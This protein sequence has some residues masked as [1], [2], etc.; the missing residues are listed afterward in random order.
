MDLH[1]QLEPIA[2]LLGDW[3]GGGSGEF[4]TIQPFRYREELHF[5]H[6]GK[7]ILNYSQRTFHADDGR[8]LHSESGYWR[9]TASG[10]VEVLLAHTTGHVEL[11]LGSAAGPHIDLRS[12]TLQGAPS[13]KDV[14]GVERRYQLRDDLLLAEFSM[15][16]MGE[17]MTLHLRSALRR[18]DSR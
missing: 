8:P 18:A 16:A 7:P 13:A 5:D 4:P 3:S 11:S 10:E 6:V 12:V 17:P 14:S 15:A 2:F 9:V 1:P